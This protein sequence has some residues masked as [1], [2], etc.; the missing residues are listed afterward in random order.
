MSDQ[1]VSVPEKANG[2]AITSL[3]C[4][5]TAW[6]IALI[7]L[8]LNVGIL[9]LFTVATLGIGGIFYI[10]TAAIGCLSPVGWLVGAITGYAAK[11]QIRQTGEGGNG[12][13]SAGLIMSIIGLGITILA[14]CIVGILAAAGAIQLP[15]PSS[16]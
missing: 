10:C 16:Y 5:I 14:I 15:S 1:P 6:I 8:C 4:G 7:L 2:L 9:P 11:N 3:L 13:A 12:M